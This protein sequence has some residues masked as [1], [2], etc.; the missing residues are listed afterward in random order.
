MATATIAQ[1]K[2]VKNYE[3]RVAH[4]LKI[5]KEMPADEAM[6]IVNEK[7]KRIDAIA[8]QFGIE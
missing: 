1:L 2:E 7:K 4:F 5:S 6:I 3:G 8:E